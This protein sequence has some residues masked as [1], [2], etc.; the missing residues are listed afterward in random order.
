MSFT[1]CLTVIVKVKFPYLVECVFLAG[2]FERTFCGI[3]V[4][5]DFGLEIRDK[6]LYIAFDF[7]FVLVEPRNVTC[8]CGNIAYA[9]VIF[10]KYLVVE[11]VIYS[12]KSHIGVG[13]RGSVDGAHR[14]LVVFTGTVFVKTDYIR[15]INR[16]T[17]RI[18]GVEE[19]IEV[20]EYVFYSKIYAVR[21]F[22]AFLNK[23]VVTGVLRQSLFFG[24]FAARVDIRYIEV[25][26]YAGVIIAILI[27]GTFGGKHAYLGHADYF[28]VVRRGRKIRVENAVRAVYAEYEGKSLFLFGRLITARGI[29]IG[30][31]F[32]VIA[33]RSDTDSHGRDQRSCH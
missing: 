25:L 8:V 9:A 15:R 19:E 2:F 24:L 18:C 20:E 33:T 10:D 28:A 3:V 30:M 5:L 14:A 22:Y 4:V 16:R 1:F 26:G 23:E 6:R 32:F 13:S 17:A 12:E 31:R 29:V 11:P 27:I 21:E 7:C